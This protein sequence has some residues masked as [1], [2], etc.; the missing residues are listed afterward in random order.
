MHGPVTANVLHWKFAINPQS[1]DVVLPVLLILVLS[2]FEKNATSAVSDIMFENIPCF[3]RYE[4]TT[5]ST[6]RAAFCDYS[7]LG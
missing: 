6:E 3:G 4:S 7:V 2:E 5:R 1:L